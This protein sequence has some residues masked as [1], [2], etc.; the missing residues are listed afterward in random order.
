MAD[1][2]R[3]EFVRWRIARALGMRMPSARTLLVVTPELLN[4]A[5]EAA[6]AAGAE[7]DS[8]TPAA[9]PVENFLAA[10]SDLLVLCRRRLVAMAQHTRA[11]GRTRF[12]RERG[13]A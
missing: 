6:V 12:S 5:A 11:R 10:S 2:E 8:Y 4:A 1:P 3:V 7:Y 13:R 9:D